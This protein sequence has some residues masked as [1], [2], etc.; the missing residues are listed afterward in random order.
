MP[1]RYY[2]NSENHVF[3]FCSRCNT[4]HF[5]KLD[6]KFQCSFCRCT[7]YRTLNRSDAFRYGK[8]PAYFCNNCRLIKLMQTAPIEDC[9]NCKIDKFIYIQDKVSP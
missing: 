9:P 4:I 5:I 7:E 2:Y 3:I 6:H 8:S 1:E